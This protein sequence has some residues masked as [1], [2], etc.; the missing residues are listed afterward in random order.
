MNVYVV[1]LEDSFASHFIGVY[2]TKEAANR[3]VELQDREEI[4]GEQYTIN[5]VPL[6]GR[7]PSLIN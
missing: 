3:C 2:A 6:Q 5:E 1:M 7:V 4:D